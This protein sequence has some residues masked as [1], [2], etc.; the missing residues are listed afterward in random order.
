MEHAAFRVPV[1]MTKCTYNLHS[2]RVWF[3]TQ[4]I[5]H[6]KRTRIEFQNAKVKKPQN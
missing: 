4:V 3:Q 6:N 5:M 1:T 2:G